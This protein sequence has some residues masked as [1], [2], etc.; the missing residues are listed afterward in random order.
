MSN[1]QQIQSH[2]RPDNADA[3]AR[4]TDGYSRQK[5]TGEQLPAK[6]RVCTLNL[7]NGHWAALHDGFN[8]AAAHVAVVQMWALGV[9]FVK[10][11]VKIS[12]QRFQTGIQLASAGQREEFLLGCADEA[13]DKAVGLRPL[14]RGAAMLTVIECQKQLIGMGAY[15]A[16]LAPVVG[17]GGR[18][19]QVVLGI[20]GQ[21][22]VVQQQRAGFRLLAG[23]Q[24][25]KGVAAI[26]V[27][28][29]MQDEA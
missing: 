15:A 29:D 3:G 21:Y 5:Q 24:Q 25:T 1:L 9:V 26:G 7:L 13:L 6:P 20:E 19:G 16:E 2:G 4:T 10:P 8:R 14:D 18:H 22:I 27:D 28:D 12:L 11:G 17:Q 23:V